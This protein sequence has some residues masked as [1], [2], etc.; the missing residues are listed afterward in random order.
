METPSDPSVEWDDLRARIIGLGERSIRK[1]YYPELEQRLGELERFRALLDQSN[2]LIFLVAIPSGRFV[3][4]N[5][6]ACRQLGF[7]RQAILT[8]SMSELVPVSV[9]ETIASFFARGELAEQAGETILTV[10]QYD[11]GELPVEMSVRRVAFNDAVYAVIVARD[12][13]ERKHH[14]RE[15]EAIIM[16]SNALRKATT[17]ADILTVILDQSMD[18]FAADGAMLAFPNPINGGISVEMGCGAV[19]KRFTGLNVP[20]G[21]GVSRW[22][23]ENKQ[24]YLSN[25]A[26]SDELF[27]RPDLL[28]DSHCVAAVPLIA[29][30]RATGVLWIARRTDLLEHDLRLLNA[31]GD[32]AASALHRVTL[33]EQTRT[34]LRRL[35]ALHQIDMAITTN[36]DLGM[37]LNIIL[38]NVKNEL[39]MDAACILL[40]TSFTQT[41]DY[42]AGV[43]FRTDAIEQ[44]HVRLGMGHAGQAALERRTMIYPDLNR[45]LEP[46]EPPTL[47]ADEGFASQFIAPLVVKGQVK[48]V[49]E[50]FH[51][52]PFEPG[53]EWLDYFETLATQ[54]AI[55]IENTFLFENLQRSNMELRLAYDATIEGWSR[56][57]DLRD[58]ETEGHTQRVMEMTLRLADKMGI[59]DFEKVNLR[60]GALLHDIGKMGVPDEILLKPGALTDDEWK[61]MR[62]H[63]K[64]AYEMLKSIEYLRP[65]LDIPYCHHEKWD[66][67][68]Y[69]RGLR[70]NAIPL[71]ARVFAVVD[72]FDALTV[73]RPYRLAWSRE[74]VRD[75]I[76]EQSG[77]HFDPQVAAAF[78]EIE[79]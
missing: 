27:Y 29:K 9:W 26:D 5:E 18:L 71:A 56:A 77:K 28:A 60:R 31:I 15:R 39:E 57:L 4:V 73:D 78:L 55:A 69:P 22:I 12:I 25:H 75:Y 53:Q 10:F 38:G 44:V 6:S 63:P 49:L 36:F 66:G 65:A 45:S 42:A 54:T 74:K 23:I 48:G 46:L 61:I 68:G 67:S 79:W 41:L 35:V 30:E 62:Q 76:F 59:G 33:Y 13:T 32:I 40:L 2:D 51:C 72:V 7:L 37:I 17:R 19:G 70:G 8:M 47:A 50:V 24:P 64:Y 34:Q 11:G 43:G 1:S 14:E 20:P 21:K 3:D 52:R 58:K 16:V